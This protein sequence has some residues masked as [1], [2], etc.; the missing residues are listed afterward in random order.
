MSER[1]PPGG[2]AGGK[3]AP[4]RATRPVRT[5]PQSRGGRNAE[6]DRFGIYF[7]VG[8]AVLIFAFGAVVWG[9][10]G[11]N[12]SNA[13]QPA[14]TPTATVAVLSL[15]G[16]PS[17]TLPAPNALTEGAFATA[18]P[19]TSIVTDVTKLPPAEVL[20]PVL[21]Q[22]KLELSNSSVNLGTVAAGSVV[23]HELTLANPGAR[24][25]VIRRLET[26]CACL[27][28]RAEASKLPSGTRT[29]LL[30]TY[31]A[32]ADPGASGAVAHKV[33]V[34]STDGQT[35][36]TTIDVSVTNP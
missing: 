14:P 7:I 15:T 31:D 21:P 11:A 17:P 36:W 2:P 4:G 3:P 12:R 34:L 19:I 9:L 5:V 35:P 16:L 25:L 33:A 27:M 23:T 1:Q 13:V 26:D 8:L 20:P 32:A 6:P 28:A 10:R 18:A 29:H 24:D 22:P 30:L